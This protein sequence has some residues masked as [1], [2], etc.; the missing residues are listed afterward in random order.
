[1]REFFKGLLVAFVISLC[2]CNFARAQIVDEVSFSGVMP[3]VNGA[4]PIESFSISNGGTIG[5]LAFS[6]T[7]TE[8]NSSDP[9][10]SD[11]RFNYSSFAVMGLGIQLSNSLQGTVPFEG[12]VEFQNPIAITAGDQWS[13]SFFDEFDDGGGDGLADV[14]VDITFRFLEESP[15]GVTDLGDFTLDDGFY[16]RFGNGDADHPFTQVP[17]QVTRDGVYSLE[18]DWDDGTGTGTFFDGFLLLF[19]EPFDGVDDSANL[20]FNDD[21]PE[22]DAD[23]RIDGIFLQAG[24]TYYAVLTTLPGQP[25][26]SG[27]QGDLRVESLS[28]ASAFLVDPVLLGDVDLSGTVDFLDISPF[29]AVLSNSQFQEEADIN[30]SGVVD[31][32]DIGPFI[33]IL[34]AGN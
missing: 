9:F 34:S 27:L 31:F 30:G 13:F 29:I 32:L 15:N 18:S 4:G 22:G 5:A 26:N 7:I 20:V 2:A 17:F 28:G 16:A 23:S 19:D 8:I 12:V 6:G 21:G 25:R 14:S 10:A 3:A 1:M 11:V 24:V 33:E